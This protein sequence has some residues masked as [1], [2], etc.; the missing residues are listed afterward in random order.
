MNI[1]RFQHFMS[2]YF[3]SFLL[4]LLTFI[5]VLLAFGFWLLL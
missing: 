2:L 3:V 5:G 1:Y 4:L